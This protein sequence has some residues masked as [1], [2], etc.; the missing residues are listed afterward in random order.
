MRV[1]TFVE[2]TMAK[3]EAFQGSGKAENIATALTVGAATAKVVGT[4]VPGKYVHCYC[5]TQLGQ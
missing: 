4:C 2:E 3:V 5:I 1:P